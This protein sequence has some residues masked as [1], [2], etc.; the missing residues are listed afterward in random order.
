MTLLRYAV[1][2][3][4]P[5]LAFH[6]RLLHLD[7]RQFHTVAEQVA[8]QGSLGFNGLLLFDDQG[9]SENVGEEKDKE[10][11]LLA[12]P[13]LLCGIGHRE[14]ILLGLGFTSIRWLLQGGCGNFLGLGACHQDA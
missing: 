2:F 5:L 11:A 14:P 10:D 7:L 12:N 1:A 9:G 6:G 8:N 13:R 3:P 4:P